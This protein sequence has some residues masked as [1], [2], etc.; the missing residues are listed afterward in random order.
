MDA[1][2][3]K[4][5]AAVCLKAVYQTPKEAQIAKYFSSP[6]LFQEPTNHSVPI[7]D[8]FQDPSTPDFEYLVMPLLRPF[9][10]PDF[11]VVGEVVDF[12]TQIL[13]VRVLNYLFRQ[14]SN[15]Q[16]GL[17]FM[18][19]HNIAHGY[20]SFRDGPTESQ[21]MKNR[22][23]AGANIM[24]DA[25]PIYPQGWHFKANICAPDGVTFV[26]PLARIDH[27]VRYYF[28]DYGVSHRF[29]PGQSHLVLD[30]GGRDA[31]VPELKKLQ[32]Y[33]PFKVDVFTVGNVFLKDFYQVSAHS[34]CY[35]HC[36]FTIPEKY[37]GLE[38]LADLVKFMMNDNPANRPSSQMALEKWCKI[39]AGLNP[40]TA[41]W[42]LRKPD[43]TV[44]E[45]VVLDAIAAARQGIH[46]LTHLFNEDV[47]ATLY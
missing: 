25:R 34:P 47:R 42:R 5:G 29:V 26:T 1:K 31:D 41:R 17:T 23:C 43:E 32:P 7:L 14:D 30:W 4:D 18:H 3:V 28:I 11:T 8:V 16:Q 38:F 19:S 45:R 39:K 37:L 12:V 35:S 21:L 10:D 13:E 46:S 44:G 9:D 22:D 20:V 24:M 36:Q 6:E 15:C 40:T 2:R 33:D 27:P